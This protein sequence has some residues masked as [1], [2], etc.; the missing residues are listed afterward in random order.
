M[1]TVSCQVVKVL[2]ETFPGE[3][4]VKEDLLQARCATHE[5]EVH[6]F[7]LRERGFVR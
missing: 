3:E 7:F 1:L 4:V 2:R 5:R 6:L